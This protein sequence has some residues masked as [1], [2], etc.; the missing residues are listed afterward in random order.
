MAPENK[1][2]TPTKKEDKMAEADVKVERFKLADLESGK[3]I[4]SRGGA[5]FG[6]IR[7]I[8]ANVLREKTDAVEFYQI[9]KVV[10]KE[11]TLSSPQQA[12]NYVTNAVRK[13][14]RFFVLKRDNRNIIVRVDADD[15]LVNR[16]KAKYGMEEEVAE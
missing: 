8:V 14:P 7:E 16:L 3:H 4:V 5:Q 1:Q 10:K 12:Y 2:V 11:L 6:K 9:V 15:V 13:D